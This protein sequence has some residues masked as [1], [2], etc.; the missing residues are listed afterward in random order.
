MKLEC[1]TD[2]KTLDPKCGDCKLCQAVSK[3]RYLFDEDLRRSQKLVDALIKLV[4]DS[5]SFHCVQPEQVK[6]P[7]I[8]VYNNKEEL[9][10]RIEAKMLEDK[11][12]MRVHELLP[13]R[14]L[15]PKETIVVDLPKLKSYFER[16]EEDKKENGRDIPTFVVWRLGRPC[17]ET[18]GITVFQECLKLKEI[19]QKKGKGRY[20]ERKTG[21]GDF[22]G[23]QKLG[24]TKKYHYSVR[25]CRPITELV[26]ELKALEE[27]GSKT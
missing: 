14:D 26:D 12:F 23:G 5:T 16:R 24:V 19:F 17:A 10:C 9:V 8:R 7:D 20:F 13:G 2:L 1:S 25:E 21:T 11:P 4:K 15:Y 6:N 22:R 18:G 27:A 3:D